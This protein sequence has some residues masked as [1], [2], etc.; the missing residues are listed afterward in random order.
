M[1]SSPKPGKSETYPQPAPAGKDE[2]AELAGCLREGIP[3][4]ESCLLN[5]QLELP[6]MGAVE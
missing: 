4:R 3:L 5:Q 1:S 2:F 6:T